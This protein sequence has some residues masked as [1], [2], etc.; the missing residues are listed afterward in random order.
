MSKSNAFM[1]KMAAEGF[2][3]K[4]SD[5][6][7]KEQ[8]KEVAKIAKKAD[9]RQGE[10]K[11][12]DVESNPSLSYTWTAHHLTSVSQ[13]DGDNAERVGDELTQRSIQMYGTIVGADT[14]NVVRLVLI[15]YLQSGTPSATD[16]FTNDTSIYA[17]LSLYTHD[18]RKRFHEIWDSGPIPVAVGNQGI[19]NR[20][21]KMSRSLKNFKMKYQG[22]TTTPERG[23]LFLFMCSDSSAVSHPAYA[24]KARV[25]YKDN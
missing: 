5:K 24:Y 9:Q 4:G 15:R 25:N 10:T 18:K 2:I 1:R 6:L 23:G 22:A 8:K 7:S 13:G 3:F 21:I 17:P 16:V 19:P 20:V 11:H 14:T 12:V